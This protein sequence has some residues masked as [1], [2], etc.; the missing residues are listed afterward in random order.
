[1]LKNKKNVDIN[2]IAHYCQEYRRVEKKLPGQ[3]QKHLDR[4]RLDAL[5][6]F[7]A[8]GFPS[9]KHADWKYTSLTALCQTPYFIVAPKP[10]NLDIVTLYSQQL[11]FWQG[12]TIMSNR[13]VY[14]IHE[15]CD[16]R[17]TQ[18]MSSAKSIDPLSSDYRLVFVNGFFAAHLSTI[19]MLAD[20]SIIS[21]LCAMLNQYPEQL[22]ATW[23]PKETVAENCFTHLNTAF[24]QDGVYIYL[25][26]NTRLCSPIEI[27]FINTDEISQ[28]F[29]PL[30]NIIIAEE[31]TQATIIEKYIDMT[32]ENNTNYFTNTVTECC[33]AANSHIEHYKAIT[34]S[35]QAQHV[36]S[37]Y[38]T[39]Q[40]HS[41]FSAYSLA[42]SGALIR[43]DVIVK[44][45]APDAH[46]QLK[47]LYYAVGQQQVDHTTQIDHV[48]P[49][50]RSE[51]FYKGIIDDRARAAF[52]GKVIVREQAIK[53]KAQQLN[54]N[55]LLSP[56]AEVNSKPQ[57]EIFAD[58]IQCTHGASIGQLDKDALF[59]LR[60]RGLSVSAAT[61]LLVKAFIQDIIEQMPLFNDVTLPS[62]IKKTYESI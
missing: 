5:E 25:A 4:L 51:E 12:A 33:L 37:L 44:L 50:T 27:L 11:D 23:K 18:T 40:Q 30:R 29:I 7:S 20:N 39:Q 31:N 47:G 26:A 43:S 53:S 21:N 61:E 17:D 6:Q 42:L 56:F 57:L 8:H 38:V 54:K 48:S 35:K 62:L 16:P 52:N 1:M 46:C 49:H 9:K 32:R 41:Q 10:C 45:L 60:T 3:G 36:G 28:H 13:N 34:E 59:Y 19:P 15:D 24:M 14:N 2:A 55:L 22:N 58:D